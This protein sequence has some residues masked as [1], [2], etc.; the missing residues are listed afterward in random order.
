MD[1]QILIWGIQN[2]SSPNRIEMIARSRS[3]ILDLRNGGTRIIVPSVALSEFLN[4][5]EIYEFGNIV[6]YLSTIAAISPFDIIAASLSAE[7]W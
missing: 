3:L 2:S 4:G 6:Q 1:T 5:I 7:I